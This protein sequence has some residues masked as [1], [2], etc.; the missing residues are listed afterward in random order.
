MKLRYLLG[1]PSGLCLSAMLAQAQEANQAEKFEKQLKEIQENFEKQ[2]REARES[3]EKML[4]EQ[5]A[6]IEALK[7]QLEASKTNV[8]PATVTPPEL[9]APPAQAL[10]GQPWTPSQPMRFGSAQNYINLSF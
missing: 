3:F 1:W 7:K 8:V 4:R 6:Q 9:A 2:Q 10:S 5:Q